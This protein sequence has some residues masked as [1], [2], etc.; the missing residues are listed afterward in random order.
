MFT[1]GSQPTP[2]A[3]PDGGTMTPSSKK[4]HSNYKRTP[5]YKRLKDGYK[6]GELNRDE[7]KEEKMKLK[8]RSREMVPRR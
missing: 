5:N 6:N 1:D 7:F 4:K 8:K 2:K 3:L